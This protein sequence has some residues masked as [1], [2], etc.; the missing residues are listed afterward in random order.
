MGLYGV[1]PKL[2]AIPG[3]EAAGVIEEVGKNVK[4]FSIGDRV[5]LTIGAA[6]SLGTWKEY[7]TVTPNPNPNPNPTV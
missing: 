7:T 4:G 6:G 2:P 1:K 3:N 5:T